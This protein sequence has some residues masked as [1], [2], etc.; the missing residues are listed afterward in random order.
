MISKSISLKNRYLCQVVWV[1]LYK[2]T[3][4][5]HLLVFVY[6]ML[7]FRH[8]IENLSHIIP[9]DSY[10]YARIVVRLA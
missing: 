10:A 8:L 3:I 7:T 6:S 1:I 5:Y 4:A 9:L 2:V